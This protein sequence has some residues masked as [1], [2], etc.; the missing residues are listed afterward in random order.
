MRRFVLCSVVGGY[1]TLG[2]AGIG[3]AA[4]TAPEALARLDQ[5]IDANDVQERAIA[6]EQIRRGMKGEA[7]TAR[8]AARLPA[9]PPDRQI[10]LLR[11]LADR[12]DAAALPAIAKLAEA[13]DTAVRS[14][15]LH[16]IGGLGSGESVGLL[17]KALA[18]TDPEKAAARRALVILR[19][20]DATRQV[21]AAL[22]S[23]PPAVRALLLDIV[24]DRR[25]RAAVPELVGFAVDADGGVRAATMRALATL[26]GPEQVPGMVKGVL[27]AA[28]GQERTDAE[29]AL[30]TV[31]TQNPGHEQA[32]ESFLTI[33]KTASD[34]DRE[35]LLSPLGRIGGP[36][37]M[38]V[39]DAL[40]ADTDPAKREFGLVAL[41]RWPDATVAP[42]LL[43]LLAKATDQ[44]KDQGQ[45]QGERDMLLSA[46]I[47][48]APLPDNKLNDQQKL[49]L[50]QKTM[51][52]CQRDE[53]RR[54]VLERANA[55][56]TIETLRFVVPYLDDPNLAEPA[57]LSVVELAHHRNIR[58]AN[59][60]E[61]TKALDKVLG[62]TKNEELIDRAERY[63]Q[64]QTW[65]RKKPSKS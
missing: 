18:A 58:D 8:F 48:I 34:A 46:L 19:G 44:D 38:A 30:V 61:F 3:G 16:A 54:R 60:D 12:G 55:I 52:L 28:A 63:K 9:L 41:T 57:C 2:L 62:T 24:A 65:E 26:G 56:R 32:T 42:R 5:L 1:V 22:A 17:V 23:A 25:A 15:A 50:L 27:T 14:A 47:R 40:L 59:K 11:A 36:G 6:Y 45:G 4:D 37:A 29:R 33:F 39:V 64:G 21:V 53:D 13:G 35:V 43:D 10:E 51:S 31:C 49:E 7:A 20:D